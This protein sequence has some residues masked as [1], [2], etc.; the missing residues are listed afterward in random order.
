MHRPG[1]C[2]RFFAN[3][4]EW[5]IRWIRR[6]R[7]ARRIDHPDSPITINAWHHAH[8]CQAI[9]EFRQPYGLSV[10]AAGAV[11][12]A[13]Q[14]NSRIVKLSRSGS[15]LATCG[16]YGNLAGQFN[17]PRMVAVDARGDL[18]VA[19]N[20]N[21]RVQRLSAPS[22]WRNGAVAAARPASS[23]ARESGRRRGG[24][25]GRSGCDN[26]RLQR[27]VPNVT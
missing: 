7:R 4:A 15:T 9:G 11:Y 13:D 1:A 3:P 25:S 2:Y 18:Y 27:Y 21:H 5:C 6:C 17:Y 12:P 8:M 10:D 14:W 24:R 19:D 20:F 26:H 23:D 22:R 16:S